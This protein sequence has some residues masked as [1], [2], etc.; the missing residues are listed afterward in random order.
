MPDQV[1]TLVDRGTRAYGRFATRPRTVNPL[2]EF[3]GT[4]RR[5]RRLRLKEWV[6]FTLVH[7]DLFSSMIIQDANYLASSEL[8]AYDR[9]AGALYQHAANA[10]GGSLRMPEVL[11]GSRPVFA[12]PGYRLEYAFAAGGGGRH[13]IIIDIAATAKAPAVR[14]ALELDAERASEPLSV[15]SRV[16]GGRLY[17][18]KALF[19]VA[20][21]Y[22]VGD[23]T[24]AFDPARD[25]AIIDEHKS[26]F[27]YMTRWLWGTLAFIG[28]DG[29]PVGA[30]FCARPGVPGEEEESCLWLPGRCEP[31]SGVTFTPPSP[32]PNQGSSMAPWQVAS[33]DGRLE[34][35]F[36]PQG[37]KDVKAQLGVAALDYYQ[38]F[39]SYRGTL[40]SLDGLVYPV[41]YA[42]GVCESFRARL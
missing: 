33:A 32:A 18:H 34:L 41:T 20:G 25:L 3:T 5:L 29:T 28:D 4:S 36:T 39:G 13:Q 38:L 17:T 6:G 16:P 11:S 8:Y 9:V 12:R 22:A 23:R 7:P 27:P 40:R 37:R 19:P 21:S 24:F 35:T 42:H 31:L 14:A 2:E 1:E 30:N 15:S 10:R 26:F